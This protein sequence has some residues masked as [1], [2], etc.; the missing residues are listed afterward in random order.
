[1]TNFA[2]IDTIAT[3]LEHRAVDVAQRAI[4]TMGW[5]E[6]RHGSLDLIVTSVSRP[7]SSAPPSQ[8]NAQRGSSRIRFGGR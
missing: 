1:M 6:G 3:T 2:S 8:A 4:G 5:Q 7:A